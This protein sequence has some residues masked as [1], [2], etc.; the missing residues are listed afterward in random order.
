[1]TI[2]FER[3]LFNI[4]T[5]LPDVL[6]FACISRRSPT[7]QLNIIHDSLLQIH[8]IFIMQ[9]GISA[10]IVTWLQS[11]RLEESGIFSRLRWSEFFQLAIPEHLWSSP[12][13]VSGWSLGFFPRDIKLTTD[14]RLIPDV[15]K[16]WTNIS[17]SMPRFIVDA[18]IS[19]ALSSYRPVTL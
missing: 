16:D 13:F 14:F 7:Q 10:N 4:S 19:N 18:H 11:E 6:V 9:P 12:S 17:T 8:A 1:M 2:A 15:K 5:A 3:Q